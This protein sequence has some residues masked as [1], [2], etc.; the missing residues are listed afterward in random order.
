MSKFSIDISK[1]VEKTKKS[2]EVVM[3]SVMIKLFSAIIKASPVDTG[4]F[5]MNW[6][7]SG[8]EPFS[9]VTEE[10]D[11][12]GANA[13]NRMTSFVTNYSGWQEI[14]LANNLDYAQDL[15]FGTSKQAPLGVV[16]V[17]V[18]RFSQL[19]NEEAAKVR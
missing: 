5:R 17:N 15:E 1:F 14:T 2:P 16:R 19:I 4:R 9:G 7:A 3:R 12:S 11:P 18:Q 6:T 8:I 13:T 10:T